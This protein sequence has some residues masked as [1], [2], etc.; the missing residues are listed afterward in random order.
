MTRIIE[1]IDFDVL[2]GSVPESDAR[3][4]PFPQVAKACRT[5]ALVM[6]TAVTAAPMTTL[7]QIL[8]SIRMMRYRQTAMTMAMQIALEE[9]LHGWTRDGNGRPDTPAAAYWEQD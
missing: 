9:I 4:L 7:T 6:A 5:P 2:R 3:N 8:T 1:T